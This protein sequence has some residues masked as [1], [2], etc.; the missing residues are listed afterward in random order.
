MWLSEPFHYVV[1]KLY[2][3]KLEYKHTLTFFAITE[4][5]KL[6]YS[7]FFR[8]HFLNKFNRYF[9]HQGSEWQ[10]WTSSFPYLYQ[11][12]RNR[13]SFCYSTEVLPCS[14]ELVMQLDETPCFAQSSTL[15]GNPF[16]KFTSPILKL[17]TYFNLI[18]PVQRA[19]S[20]CC[21]SDD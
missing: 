5:S 20:E 10:I 6:C 15:Q 12:E 9:S 19:A 1:C 18:T 21:L 3:D 2:L 11:N 13:L 14:A 16:H 7:S 4:L 8:R 17:I